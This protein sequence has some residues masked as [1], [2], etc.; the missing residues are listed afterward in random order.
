MEIYTWDINQRKY[1]IIKGYC[2][3]WTVRRT[4]P[5]I[6]AENGGVSYSLNVA[7]LAHFRISALKD[8]IKYFTTFFASKIFFPIFLLQNLRAS[9]DPKNTGNFIV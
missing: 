1:V 3:V 7:Y 6:W 2:I 5:Q 8:V 4:T 9:Y